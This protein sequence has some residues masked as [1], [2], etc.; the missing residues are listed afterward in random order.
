MKLVIAVIRPY[1]IEEVQEALAQLGIAR[2]NI[3]EAKR[4]GPYKGHTVVGR[5]R[6]YAAGFVPK[7]KVEVVVPASL[8]D[9]VVDAIA[10]SARTNEAGDGEIIVMGIDRR[11]GIHTGETDFGG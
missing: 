5:G 10:R 2:F 3:T 7:I 6:E 9:K 1:K 4:F 11:M 8:V